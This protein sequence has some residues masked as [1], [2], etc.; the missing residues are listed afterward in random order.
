[1]Q[2]TVST[3][4]VARLP[5]H[6]WGFPGNGAATGRSLSVT[7]AFRPAPTVSMPKRIVA[8]ECQ[9]SNPDRNKTEYRIRDRPHDELA[10]IRNRLHTLEDILFDHLTAT[11]GESSN[12]LRARLAPSHRGSGDAMD[13]DHAASHERF[14]SSPLDGPLRG[15]QSPI[16]SA[17]IPTP[18]GSHRA[19]TSQIQDPFHVFRSSE[20]SQPRDSRVDCS[21]V[22]RRCGPH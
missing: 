16:S 21:H 13:T 10:Q 1:M 7:P 12:A 15:T 6:H 9:V 14:R 22:Q 17:W 18:E 20:S 5:T 8:S 2:A 4:H 3:S 19:T 11:H